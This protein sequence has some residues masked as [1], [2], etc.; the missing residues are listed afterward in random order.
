MAT[1]PTKVGSAFPA[2][3]IFSYIPAATDPGPITTSAS[4]VP[5]NA[6]EGSAPTKPASA[7][8]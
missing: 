5:Y 8:D 7:I 6:S 2:N 1:T 3:M 4:P